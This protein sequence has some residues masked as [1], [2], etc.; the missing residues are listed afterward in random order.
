MSSPRAPI[1]R[2]AGP[3]LFLERPSLWLSNTTGAQ[4]A[5]FMSDGSRCLKQESCTSHYHE[6]HQTRGPAAGEAGALVNRK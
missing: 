2:P 4:E 1:L 5:V 3:G 6:A